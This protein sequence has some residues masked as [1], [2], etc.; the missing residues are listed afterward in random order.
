MP[1]PDVPRRAPD[2]RGR[3]RARATSRRRRPSSARSRCSTPSASRTPATARSDYPHQ[4]SGGMRQRAMI[5]MALVHN[6]VGADRRRADDRA[7]RD[8]AGPD[9]RADRQGQARLRHRRDPDHARPRRRRR[10]RAD[11]DGHVRRAAPSS[12]ARRDEVFDSP[13]HPYTWGLLESMP[14]IE[15]K[16]AHLHA[17]EGSPPSV[18][19]LPPGLRRSIR[20]ARTA[21]SRCDKVRPVARAR[22]RAGTPTPATSTPTTKRR[23][24]AEREAARLGV[25]RMSTTGDAADRGRAPDQA[26]PG[27]HRACSRAARARCTRS[28]T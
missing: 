25:E 1:A 5:A 2:R 8:R 17:I 6:P 7:R 15:A 23:L 13:Q 27:R 4:F 12:T 10:D 26:L 19:H 22:S 11:R 20:A 16:V 3:A 9:P 14:S 24:W 28:R 21:S 18:I